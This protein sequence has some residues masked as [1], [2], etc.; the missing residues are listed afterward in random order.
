MGTITIGSKIMQRANN[1]LG[2]TKKCV[3]CMA[4]SYWIVYFKKFFFFHLRGPNW[5]SSRSEVLFLKKLI[6]FLEIS[7]N[8]QE[9][10]C[11]RVSFLIKLEASVCTSGG[12]FCTWWKTNILI[13]KIFN[14]E[15]YA[16]TPVII[17]S[18]LLLNK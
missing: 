6:N 8:S 18:V 1:L 17:T 4:Q 9:N 11:G 12:C 13:H 10:I 15:W 14:N 16:T 2:I 7:K 3:Q 5:K